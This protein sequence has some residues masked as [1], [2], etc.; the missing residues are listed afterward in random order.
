MEQFLKPLFLGVSLVLSPL[1]AQEDAKF[2][3]DAKAC[4]E[5]LS[6]YQDYFTQWQ[7]S[8]D[9]VKLKDA[10]P[11]LDK[12]LQ[13]CPMYNV[14]TYLRGKIIYE[15]LLKAEKDP[16]QKASL[17]AKSVQM[18]DW[19][20]QYFN[21]EKGTDLA[22]INGL[23][24]RFVYQFGADKAEARTLMQSAVDAKKGE[25]DPYVIY[26]L[27]LL[28]NDLLKDG[29]IEL[30]EVL[31]DFGKFQ[32]YLEDYAK[33]DAKNSKVTDWV[34]SAMQ[35]YFT[36]IA[37]C[38]QIEPM[39]QK[40]IQAQAEINNK[41]K[42]VDVMRAARCTKSDLFIKTAENVCA[43]MPSLDCYVSLTTGYLERKDYLKASNSVEKLL[44]Q[45][46]TCEKQNDYKEL[47]M[48]TATAAGKFAQ[49]KTY[50]QEL[51]LKGQVLT[52]T[53]QQIAEKAKTCE[54]A[55]DRRAMYWLAYDYAAKAK[56]VD[57]KMAQEATQLMNAYKTAFPTKEEIFDF[58]GKEKTY[59]VACWN[60]E[61]TEVRAVEN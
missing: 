11:F 48:K 20:L 36:K 39:A 57:A 31:E 56:E 25:S 47:A 21:G 61:T 3:S 28:K 4:R 16:A 42:W 58:L 52:I 44:E 55:F 60:Q 23:K 51:G 54:K 17:L 33:L 35:P 46:G 9:I 26:Y 22:L 6:L 50:A 41:A 30:A 18:F 37:N 53:A 5:N 45:C 8:K 24:G 27:Y 29:K 38:A 2:G 34:K 7:E 49:A 43:S 19:Q 40:S 13:I 32:G 15:E 14:A 12:A 10:E 59:N 1:F